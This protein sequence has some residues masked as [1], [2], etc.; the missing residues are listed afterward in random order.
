MFF[1][2]AETNVAS[3]PVVSNNAP[4]SSHDAIDYLS[5]FIADALASKRDKVNKKGSANSTTDNLSE[6]LIKRYILPHINLYKNY[7]QN[8]KKGIV[9]GDGGK[10]GGKQFNSDKRSSIW[11]ASNLLVNLR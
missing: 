6:E 2:S 3:H 9:E 5:N 7:Q 8:G 11:Y 1:Y 10:I 4:T